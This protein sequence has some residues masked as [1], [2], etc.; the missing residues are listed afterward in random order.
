MCS[1][2]DAKVP[3]CPERW[4]RGGWGGGMIWNVQKCCH[5]VVPSGQSKVLG[6][7]R[8]KPAPGGLLPH[9][10]FPFSHLFQFDMTAPPPAQH[11]P[12]SRVATNSCLN[13]IWEFGIFFL[14]R[15]QLL[16]ALLNPSAYF[17]T[18]SSERALHGESG[19]RVSPVRAVS[20]A[21]QLRAQATKPGRVGSC[22]PPELLLLAALST[23]PVLDAGLYPQ[24][25]KAPLQ[26]LW[27][28]P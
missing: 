22:H 16:N 11:T 4:P 20:S 6:A 24:L 2:L 5:L 17:G 25:P 21:A 8:N 27:Q 28:L 10:H 1:S 13:I 19:R 7:D 23:K 14:K 26:T 18:L 9:S 3:R 15:A 12:C